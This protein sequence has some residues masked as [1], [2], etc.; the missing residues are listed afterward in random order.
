MP[1]IRVTVQPSGMQKVF[2]VPEGGA[3]CDVLALQLKEEFGSGNLHHAGSNNALLPLANVYLQDGDYDYRTFAGRRLLR[4]CSLNTC[5]LSYAALCCSARLLPTCML[6][7][8][9][10]SSKLGL[11]LLLV[12]CKQR[13]ARAYLHYLVS[14]VSQ[15]MLAHFHNIRQALQHHH[16]SSCMLHATVLLRCGM[17]CSTLC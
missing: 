7:V 3:P 8:Q 1:L 11:H 12:P 13:F 14:A 10:G 4:S 17:L 6:N 15:L 5:C 2:D 9:A 16:A